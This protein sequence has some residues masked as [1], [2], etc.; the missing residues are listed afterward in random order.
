MG[1]IEKFKLKYNFSREFNAD[2][3]PFREKLGLALLLSTFGVFVLSAYGIMVLDQ[4]VHIVGII[5]SVVIFFTGIY[6]LN[7]S[8]IP[9]E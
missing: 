3:F 7:K 2:V 5:M 6:I 9:R 8:C 1:L 4:A